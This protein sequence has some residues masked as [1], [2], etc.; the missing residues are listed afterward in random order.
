MKISTGGRHLR[1]GFK[2][3]W[4]NGWMSFAS[5]S[6][7]AITLLILSV[8]LTIALNAVQM[9][10]FVTDQLQIS[11]YL[12][13]K[14]TT[15]QGHIIEQEIQ[16]IPGV[17]SV[18]YITKEQG[19]AHMQQV[20]G[21]Q[22]V[23]LSQIGPNP[24]PDEIIVKST[25]PKQTASIGHQIND[26]PGVAEVKDGLAI[27]NKLYRVLDLVRNIGLVL[28]VAL[29]I[30]AMFL[31]SNTIK[32]TIFSRRR[33]IEIMK[34]VGATNWFIRWPFL[35]EGMVIGVMGALLPFAAV[36]AGYVY[37]FHFAAGVFPGLNFPLVLPL[38]V[39]NKL[40]IVIFGLGLLIGVWGGVMSIRKFLRV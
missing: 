12:D 37:L 30:T 29:V 21:S 18:Q 35:V 17:K 5:V 11:V 28:V 31:I 33:E 34:L 32:V 16:K 6:S 4:R 39:A 8:F 14:I 9:R 7:V 26:L 38:A 13:T 10:Q 19:L 15:A 3:I 25:D 2:N 40:G 23:V 22:Q 1:E 20:L 27:V 36:V 24:L